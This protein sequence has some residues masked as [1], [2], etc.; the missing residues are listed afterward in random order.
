MDRVKVTLIQSGAIIKNY[1]ADFIAAIAN[2]LEIRT[3]MF[4]EAHAILS[5]L[6]YE[7]ELGL[8]NLWI[9]SDSLS[10]VNILNGNMNT[11]GHIWYIVKEIK[12][13]LTAL[14]DFRLSHI[15]REGNQPADIVAKWSIDNHIN[16]KFTDIRWL[17]I[18]VRGAI[19]LDKQGLPR[20]RQRENTDL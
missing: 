5:R 16:S 12:K 2:Y 7:V 13:L 20:I 10:L 18:E 3:P 9:E 11:P 15:F 4:A 1:K 14:H 19:K 6:Q 17:P 8:N